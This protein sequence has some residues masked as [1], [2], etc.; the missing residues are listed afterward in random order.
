MKTDDLISLLSKDAQVR[1][2]LGSVLTGALSMGVIVSAA[3]LIATVGLRPDIATV[4]GTPRVLL[5]IVT[6][7]ALA[8]AACGLVFRIGRPGVP[9]KLSALSLLFPAVLVC[10]GVVFELLALPTDMWRAAVLGRN[11]AY[12]V[13]FI[14]IFSLPPLVGFLWALKNAAPAT[15]TIGGA[16][17]GL[18][19]AGVSAALYAWHC[20]DDSPLFLATWYT[21]SI[22]I[23]TGIGAL[24]GSRLLRW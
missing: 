18:A 6:T 5:K 24:A 20:P 22:T 19:S 12:C 4:I 2:R 1:S 13:F 21:L 14:P 8:L 11:A 16:V 10:A 7:L 3:M 15:P 23:V 9:L 17:A